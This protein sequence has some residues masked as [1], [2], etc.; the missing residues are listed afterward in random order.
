[1]REGRS[2]HSAHGRADPVPLKDVLSAATTRLGIPAPEATGRIWTS[3]RDI[4][5]REVAAHAEP[6]SLRDG[7]LRIRVDSPA[8]ATEI[9]YLAGEIRSR[10]NAVTGGAL[11]SEVRV[12]S[13]P[14]SSPPAR[15]DKAPAGPARDPD[16]EPPADPAEALERARR[17]WAK[18]RR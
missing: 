1:V 13:G 6:T 8:W 3:W 14:R 10:A 4:V 2:G 12:W 17:A 16:R 11:V 5:G 15:P 7:I 9:S 18:R